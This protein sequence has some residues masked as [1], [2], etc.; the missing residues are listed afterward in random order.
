MCKFHL[1]SVVVAV[2]AVLLSV[3]VAAESIT[4]QE[5]VNGYTGSQDAYY[6]QSF[7]DYNYGA[8]STLLVGRQS[9]G[10]IFGALIRYDLSDLD[11][12]YSE[13]TSMTLR[14]YR[15][16]VKSTSATLE[17]LA[18]PQVSGNQ[19]WVE[20]NGVPTNMVPGAMC[21]NYQQY[22]TLAWTGGN[23]GGRGATDFYWYNSNGQ[24]AGTAGTWVDI[25]IDPATGQGGTGTITTLTGLVDQWLTEGATNAGVLIGSWG[26]SASENDWTFASRE[27]PTAGYHP[28]LVIGYTVIPEPSTLAL[29][30]TGLIGLLCY[31]WRK[32]R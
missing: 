1:I 12:Q 25:V 29:L 26:S 20:G 6:A 31:A 10:S 14:L 30:A 28:Q 22:N 32:R 16:A 17:L 21:Y 23:T 13:I 7:P 5:G 11:G 27:D 3:P 8:M 19:H 18:Y 4:L 15:T 9:S 24:V 2:V